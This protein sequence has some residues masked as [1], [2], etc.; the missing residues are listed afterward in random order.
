M[1]HILEIGAAL[2]ERM[3]T[4]ANDFKHFIS[5]LLIL[6]L[7]HYRNLGYKDSRTIVEV[8]PI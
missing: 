5:I 7:L 1:P 3:K 4:I 8:A 2:K 6:S